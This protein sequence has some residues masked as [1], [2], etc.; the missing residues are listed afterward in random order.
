MRPSRRGR[1]QGVAPDLGPVDSSLA[2]PVERQV[3]RR[4]RLKLMQGL[5]PPGAVFTSR[6]LAAELGVSA[7]PVRDALKRLEADGVLEGKPQSG[8]FL[9][10]PSPAE[11]RE[12]TEIR[13]RLEGLAARHAC[14]TISSADIDVLEHLNERMAALREPREYLAENHR[15][16]FTLYEA[17]N[18]PN[19]LS[20]IE[21]FWVR[22]GPL[23][24][25]HPYDLDHAGI[26][27]RHRAIV[28]ALRAR[29]ADAA[30]RAIAAD[31][32]FSADL[33]APLLT[34]AGSAPAGTP[35]EMAAPGHGAWAGRGRGSTDCARRGED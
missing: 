22:I 26:L 33:V 21:T 30:E 34:N 27:K 5:I 1:A 9:R 19:L 24:H 3:Y 15:F 6:S 11:Y 18:R 31:L 13:Q 32:G 17:A 23:L 12:I 7:Q 20:L 35:A 10:T 8:F 29:D 16:H 4:I 2:E 25:H 28:A 14:A